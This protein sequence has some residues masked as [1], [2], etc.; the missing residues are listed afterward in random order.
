MNKYEAAESEYYK[1]GYEAGKPKW[2]P[3]TERLP[4]PETEV[5][6]LAERKCY[7]FREKGATTFH[8]VTTRSVV[9]ILE[10]HLA[11]GE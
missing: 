10:Q 5:M 1:N 7:S 6:V 2:I 3:V 9:R 11:M 8:I 4:E